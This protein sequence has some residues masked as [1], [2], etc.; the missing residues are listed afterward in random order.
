VI[1][2]YYPTVQGKADQYALLRRISETGGRNDR[3][4]DG[5]FCHGVLNTDNMS[6]T[7]ESFDYGPYAFI[8]TY[9]RQFTA[10][11]FDYFRRY[12]YGR[13]PV[14]KLNLEVSKYR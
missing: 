5:S 3:P 8:P 2:Q 13:Q 4:M 14:C 10:A 1:E 6:I 11:Y 12:S 9:D 7:G